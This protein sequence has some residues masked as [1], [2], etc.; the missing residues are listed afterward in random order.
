MLVSVLAYVGICI[1]SSLF[2][3]HLNFD[4]PVLLICCHL[5]LISVD[6]NFSVS[7]CF[8]I[9]HL[10][11]WIFFNFIRCVYFFFKNLWHMHTFFKLILCSWMYGCCISKYREILKAICFLKMLIHEYQYVECL[12]LCY[13]IMNSN[14]IRCLF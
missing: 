7:L 13:V 11:C 5:A 12:C 10:F 9:L 4:C 6:E 2:L 3:T 8:S 1:F 14:Y